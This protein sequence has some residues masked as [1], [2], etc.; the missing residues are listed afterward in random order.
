MGHMRVV[1]DTNI[2]VY[3]EGV[4]GVPR[5]DAAVE[6]IKKLDDSSTFLPVQ[7]LGELFHVLVRKA[8]MAP[9]Q[10]RT[11]IGRWHATFPTIETSAAVLAS[12][13]DLAVHHRFNIWDTVIVAAAS[14]AQCRLVLSEDMQEGFSWG[15]ITVVNPFAARKHDL[16]ASLLAR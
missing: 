12:A 7:V 9:V 2:L 5:A 1:L 10:A 6:L 8:G 14:E 16:L 4:N 11:V 3:A 15:G 13:I